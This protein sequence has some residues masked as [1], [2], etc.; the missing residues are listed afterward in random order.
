MLS[1]FFSQHINDL[2]FGDFCL[3]LNYIKIYLDFNYNYNLVLTH[4]K[5]KK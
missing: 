5:I 3:Y 4:K 1:D 2:Y